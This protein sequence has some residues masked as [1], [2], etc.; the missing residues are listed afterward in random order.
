MSIGAGIKAAKTGIGG[1]SY[2]KISVDSLGVLV[3]PLTPWIST[4]MPVGF[5]GTE[6]I[7]VIWLSVSLRKVSACVV[8]RT[9]V[10]S[11]M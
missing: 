2:N 1:L 9:H 10:D 8:P 4:L 6:D 7:I 11:C 5:C 3:V